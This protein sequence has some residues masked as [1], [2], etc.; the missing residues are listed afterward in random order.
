MLSLVLVRASTNAWNQRWLAL[1][2]CV[3][4]YSLDV[5]WMG[6]VGGRLLWGSIHDIGYL[7]LV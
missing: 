2:S 5:C 4:F 7:V 6:L 3:P 1:L